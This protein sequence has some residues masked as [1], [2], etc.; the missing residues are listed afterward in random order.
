LRRD[1]QAVLS[2]SNTGPVIPPGEIGRLL[3]QPASPPASGTAR[4]TCVHYL[5]SKHQ[6][7]RCDQ[8]LA[9]AGWPIATGV[10]EGACRHLIGD[11]LGIGRARRG[12]DGA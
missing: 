3:Q 2:V 12:L 7:L 10:I 1:G 4:K 5:T 8:A 9:A 6:F 11:R